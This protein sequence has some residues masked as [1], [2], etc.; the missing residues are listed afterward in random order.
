MT[1][2]QTVY[3]WIT[4]TL[5]GKARVRM[6][7]ASEIRRQLETLKAIVDEYCLVLN[8]K[9]VP[10]AENKADVLIRIPKKW[11]CLENEPLACVAMT[12]IS[13]QNIANSMKLPDIQA[14]GT[15]CT[16][17]GECIQLSSGGRCRVSS[18]RVRRAVY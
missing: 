3:H 5:S 7:S 12:L 17:A 8:V 11:L 15:L 1:D 13:K 18:V 16:S 14:L 10:S 2:S 9:F 4:D 6:K